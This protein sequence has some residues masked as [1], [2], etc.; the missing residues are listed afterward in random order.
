[1]STIRYIGI[2][3]HKRHVTVAAVNAQQEIVLPP[4]KVTI[5]RLDT[6][7]RKHLLPSDQ[8]ALEATTNAWVFHDQLI[9]RV[10][11]VSVANTHKLRLIGSSA[12]K[13]DKHDA[14]V[15]AKLL[16]ARL[17]PTIWVPP[18]HQKL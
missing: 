9:L 1:M 13:T 17:L 10:A 8:V 14:L 3:V 6:W 18:G 5:A 4:Q 15:L 2:D 7:A 16:A 12:S 11:K